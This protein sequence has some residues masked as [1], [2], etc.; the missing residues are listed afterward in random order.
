[1]LLEC[2]RSLEREHDDAMEAVVVN[3]GDEIPE[4]DDA[5]ALAF[6]TVVPAGGN[7]GFAAACNLGARHARGH[8]LVF[9]NPDTVVAPGAIRELARSLDDPS[10]GLAMARLR[11]L[12]QPDVLNAAGG[13]IHLTGIAWAG[14]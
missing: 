1:M 13:E 8:A 4:L 3:N 6:V 2:L 12:R 7:I 9:L 5:R 11:L 10:V 14:D